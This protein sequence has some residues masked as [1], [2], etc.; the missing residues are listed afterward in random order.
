MPQNI[1]SGDSV[2]Y[3]YAIYKLHRWLRKAERSCSSVEVSKVAFYQHE[4]P[5]IAEKGSFTCMRRPLCILPAWGCYYRWQGQFYQHEAAAGP[6]RAT[7][8]GPSESPLPCPVFVVNVSGLKHHVCFK[9]H[10]CN[11]D[12]LWS[13]FKNV[14]EHLQWKR[15]LSAVQKNSRWWRVQNDW[16]K[17]SFPPLL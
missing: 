7:Q 16:F 1:S 10:V 13:S 5:I 3:R 14:L 9:Q 8:I 12:Q 15:R 17:C 2:V 6:K 4:T 11:G